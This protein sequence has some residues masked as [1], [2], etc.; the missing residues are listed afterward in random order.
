MGFLSKLFGGDPQKDVEKGESML[1]DGRPDRALELARKALASNQDEV[2]P[3]AEALMKK[4]RTQLIDRALEMA[5]TSEESEF[6]E[7]AVE[8][9][10]RAI[11]Q[12]DDPQ[13]KQEIVERREQLLAK[14]EAA[15]EEVWQEPEPQKPENDDHIQELPDEHLFVA[16]VDMLD[17]D[18]GHLYSNQDPAFRDAYLALN[19]DRVKEALPVLDELLALDSDN[20]VLRFER[21]RGRLYT[22]D[23]AGAR[24][25]LENAWQTWGDIFLD[26]AG[27][28]SVA[29]VWSE[30]MLGLKEPGPILERLESAARP[31]NGQ[32]ELSLPYALALVMDERFEEAE[33][34]LLSAMSLFPSKPDFSLLLAQ[35]LVDRERKQDAIGCLESAIAPS[36]ASGTCG[37]PPRHIPSFRLLA[38]LLLSSAEEQEGK[39]RDASLQRVEEL[40]SFIR[41]GMGGNLARPDVLLQ[42]ELFRLKGDEQAQQEC[43]ERAAQMSEGADKE[44]VAMETPKMSAETPI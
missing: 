15:E 37:R 33:E 42:A 36:C 34:F 11:E 2:R 13:R 29:G 12:M 25:D 44:V 6:W 38:G 9:L 4:A 10:D 8:W 28:L 24:E 23:P 27:T 39:A 30:A 14:I 40:L 1:A 3:A 41:E 31:T 18:I 5:G 43:L 26:R 35:L 20:P 32:P 7:D 19:D 22:G 17:D 21:G 16:L